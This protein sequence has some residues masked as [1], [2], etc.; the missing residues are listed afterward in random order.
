ME[1]V[2]PGKSPLLEIQSP[3]FVPFF[4]DQVAGLV[5]QTELLSAALLWLLFDGIGLKALPFVGGSDLPSILSS[6]YEILTKWQVSSSVLCMVAAGGFGVG[7][8]KWLWLPA[9]LVALAAMLFVWECRLWVVFK[10]A[11]QILLGLQ[12][13]CL[14]LAVWTLTL[15][16]RAALM[17]KPADEPF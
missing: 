2:P 9:W 1:K 13:P 17:K 6:S 15:C 8:P 7:L 16:W 12:I 10:D 5:L 14:A 3:Q 4:R 11:P